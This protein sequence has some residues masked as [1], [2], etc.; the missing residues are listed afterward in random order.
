MKKIFLKL[1]ILFLIIFI[2]SFKA[3]AD[4]SLHSL[5][6]DHMVLQQKSNIPVWGWADPGEKVTIT[7][8][9]QT[10]A[11]QTKKNGKWKITLSPL[12]AG[13]PDTMTIKGKNTLKVKDVLVGEVWLCSGQSN[14]QFNLTKSV[15]GQKALAEANYPE[16]RLF[17]VPPDTS[18]EPKEKCGGQWNVCKA[19]SKA[20]RLFSAVGFY[21]GREIHQKLNVPVGLIDNSW[22]GTKAEAWTPRKVLE[23]KK[24]LLPILQKYQKAADEY[25][26]KLKEYEKEK[27][28][29]GKKVSR[30]PS[31]P[32]NP[33]NKN[34]PSVLYNAMVS[35][36]IP[37]RIQGVIWYQGE[38]NGRRGYQ[39]RKLFQDMIQS[40]RDKWNQGTF[41]FIFVQLSAWKH[42]NNFDP[43]YWP[44]LREAQLLTLKKIPNT[45]MAV[46]IDVGDPD[47]I[48]PKNKLTVGH[49]LAL[50]ARV[51]IYGEKGLTYSG[52]IYRKMKKQ[53][54]KIQIFFDN[55]GKGLVA[56]G[57]K[58]HG[59]KIAGKGRDF[60]KANA[61][62]QNDTVI[63]SSDKIS[64]PSAVRY[65]WHE[66][67][68]NA[69]LYNKAGLPASPFR[70]D[71]WPGI[72]FQ[73]R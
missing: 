50:W 44:E 65:A 13:G 26:R 1:N 51:K 35:P 56:K 19:N 7:F 39:Y 36:L 14:M 37:Y 23:S 48:H 8:R 55:I 30:P 64:D 68:E 31:K 3:Y 59:F 42:P 57:N 71:N 62:I 17:T 54:R 63:V 47:T 46:T 70:T 11:T 5:F 66:Y 43:L 45:G 41:P 61:K 60:V 18:Q 15:N 40:W 4:I 6:N 72:S 73:N 12:S 2:F 58:L 25:P 27:K 22:G 29:Q 38:G 28:A 33:D 21:F 32:I 49:R 16:M 52:P 53:G 20:V 69:N 67:P 24:I 9:N 10:I 34:A